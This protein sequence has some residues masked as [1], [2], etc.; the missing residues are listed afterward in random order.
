[1]TF[2]LEDMTSYSRYLEYSCL[3]FCCSQFST[4]RVFL[5]SLHSP[6]SQNS[7]SIFSVT[8]SDSEYIDSSILEN[9][10]WE[11]VAS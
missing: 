1:M 4:I 2:Y 3:I 6:V 8:S 11:F 5:R 7:H 10:F 9:K